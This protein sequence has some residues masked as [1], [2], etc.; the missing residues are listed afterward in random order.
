MKASYEI[1]T[2][3]TEEG[4]IPLTRWFAKLNDARAIVKIKARIVRIGQGNFG[5]YKSLDGG[6]YE[7]RVDYGPGYRLYYCFEGTRIVLLLCAGDKR[8]QSR[9]IAQARE[10]KQEF[11]R[12]NA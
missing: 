12:R 4:A 2:Y 3:Q 1:F 8:T 11:E 9:D 10:Y 6:L 5:D 7:L